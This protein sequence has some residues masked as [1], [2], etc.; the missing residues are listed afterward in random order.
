LASIFA[1]DAGT[2]RHD[3]LGRVVIAANLT[4]SLHTRNGPLTGRLYRRC[5]GDEVFAMRLIVTLTAALT[6]LFLVLPAHP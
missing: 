4:V 1:L 6:V 3:R 5:H 2:V